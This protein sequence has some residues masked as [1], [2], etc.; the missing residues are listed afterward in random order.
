VL[1]K[2]VSPIGTNLSALQ[3][4]AGAHHYRFVGVEFAREGSASVYDTVTLIQ[5]G[6]GSNAQT[7]IAQVPH[8]LVLD[9]CYIH[10]DPTHGLKR[11]VGLHSAHTSI[12]NSYI[13]DCKHWSVEAQAICGWNGPGPFTITNNYIE[14]SGENLMFGGADP[15]IP[16]L[17]PSDIEIRRNYF[18]K[19]LAWRGNWLVKNILELKSA[20]RAIIEGNV[21]ENCWEDAQGGAAVVF[22]PRNQGGGAPWTVLEDIT[23]RNNIVRHASTGI[24]LLATDDINTSGYTRRIQIVNN[25]FYDLNSETWGGLSRVFALNGTGG[26]DWV[27]NHNTAYFASYGGFQC[28]AGLQ[29]TRLTINNNIFR[30]HFLVGG[31]VGTD[32]LTAAAGATWDFRRNVVV[33]NNLPTYYPQ[34]TTLNAAS[35][36]AVGFAN[37]GAND[38]RLASNSP[39]KGQG[40]DGKDI[41]CDIDSLNAAVNSSTPYTG[42]PSTVPGTLEAEN[43]DNGG[44]GFAYHDSNTGNNGNAY[45]S[46][47]V[48]IRAKSS[49]SNGYVVFNAVAGEWLKYSINVP[50]TGLYNVGVSTA[51]YLEGGIFH[52]EVDGVDVTGPLRAP[53]TGSWNTFQTVSKS[54]VRLTAGPH[55]LRLVLDTN[56]VEGIV[57]DFDKITIVESC[58]N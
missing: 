21:L 39:Y 9:R 11:G 45:R 7:S 49:A 1:P 43:V 16:N 2:I 44:E 26:E 24:G 15:S 29:V 53:T 41:G 30:R 42:T 20:R 58:V 48:D 33:E 52:I 4:A 27:I 17:V 37:L 23:F 38:F 22:T 54:G 8:H 55:V 5:F 51:S 40:T 13:S 10:G 14:G 32:A 6:D 34:P 19:P 57:A 50:A 28:Q 12:L 46:T 3:T 25:L 47:D 35:F 31:N 18:T 36:A 56:G